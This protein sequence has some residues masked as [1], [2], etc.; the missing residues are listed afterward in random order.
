MAATT[1]KVR[2]RRGSKTEWETIDPVLLEGEMGI[3]YPNDGI[4]A[5]NIK[6]KFGDGIRSWN[7][8]PYAIDQCEASSIH[9]GDVIN[10]KEVTIRTGTHAEWEASDPVLIKGEIAYD[11]TNG[12][13]KIGDG[14]HRF[15]E[16]RYIGQT[17]D[18]SVI[19]DFGDY[20]NPDSEVYNNK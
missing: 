7:N 19:Y 15:S 6:I 14:V 8:L 12:E 10:Y 20:D 13:I 3:E 1:V 17:W 4:S 18:I 2:P 9:A 5:G 16:L 11:S